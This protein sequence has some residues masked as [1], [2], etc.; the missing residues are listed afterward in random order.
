VNRKVCATVLI[1]IMEGTKN[2]L[3]S[4]TPRKDTH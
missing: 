3:E 2:T 4:G 1:K